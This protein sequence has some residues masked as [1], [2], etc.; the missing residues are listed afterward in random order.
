MTAQ[1]KIGEYI[2]Q[3]KF[4][5]AFVVEDTGKRLRLLNQNGREVKLSLSRLIHLTQAPLSG[6]LPREEILREL[7]D[8]AER[9]HDLMAKVDLAGIWEL[10]VEERTSV[11]DP[12]F[13]TEL[14]FGENAS[15]DHVAAFLRCVFINRLYFKYKEG[16]I[17]VHSADVVEHLLHQ[18]EKEKQQ[19]A[20]LDNGSKGLLQIWEGD[21]AAEWP[22][23]EDCLEIVHDYYLF[24][25]DAQESAV[26]R[27]LLKRSGLTRPNDGFE[28]LVKAGLWGANENLPFLRQQLS[29]SFP[30]EVLA[31]ARA[32]PEPDVATL[33]AERRRD[34]TNLPLLTIDG[35]DTKDYDDAL[36]IEKRG[37]NY[38]V[39][40][41]ISDVAYYVRPGEP[42]FEEAMNRVTSLYFPER[43]VPMLPPELSQGCCSLIA[44][45]PR[46]AVSFMVEL[47]PEGEVLDFDLLASVVE[48]KRQLSYPE[49]E[50]MADSDEELRL[51]AKMSRK[52]QQ[53]RVEAGALL[54]PIPDVNI[55]LTDGGEPIDVV[56][57]DV[58]TVSRS[59]VA[60]FMVLANTLGA[61]YVAEREV[62]GLYR[63]QEPPRKRLFVNPQKDLL[64]NYQQRRHLSP[65]KLLTDPKPHSGVGVS[66]YTTVTSPIRRF[67]DLIMQQQIKNMLTGKGALYR[68]EEMND[69]GAK[70]LTTQSRVNQVRQQRHRY[71]LL[72][73]LEPKLDQ[74]VEA[75]V[76]NRGPKR[77]QVVL[78]DC[79][80]D[81]DLPAVQAGRVEPGELVQVKLEQVNALNNQLRFAW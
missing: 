28:L 45:Q 37:D 22:E 14:S 77:V 73:Y 17:T 59:L 69:L 36:H 8:V 51:L 18:Q 11:F 32:I 27:E 39:G 35:A 41:H 48:V 72:K 30:E 60:E 66:Q 4:L 1:G 68:L 6:Q 61:Q 75:L 12:R 58:D 49:A 67:L 78:T 57:S 52:L 65:G 19:E 76:I 2:D 70:I 80:L 50:E 15:D 38:L 33:C 71:W 16:R 63:S 53:R 34:L 23:R 74:R 79:L 9:R 29:D 47:S 56:L 42:L 62:P 43:Q 40:I 13:L 55:K 54:L 7:K 26:A 24:G 20:L 64:V 46:A 5:C 10:A 44:G 21:H 25:N 81:G 31:Q 3:G